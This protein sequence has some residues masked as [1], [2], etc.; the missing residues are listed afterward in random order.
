[1]DGRTWGQAGAKGR[2]NGSLSGFCRFRAHGQAE[3]WLKWVVFV[4]LDTFLYYLLLRDKTRNLEYLF[5]SAGLK[6]G[7]SEE[8]PRIVIV[9]VI[10]I[11]NVKI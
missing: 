8:G 11:V 1:M 5:T 10:V 6:A 3:S 2:N 7:A 4:A 9:I